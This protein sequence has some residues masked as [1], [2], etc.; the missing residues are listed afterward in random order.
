MAEI[1]YKAN[2]NKYH[3]QCPISELDSMKEFLRSKGFEIKG[4]V[5]RYI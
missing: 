1:I 4:I 5:R 3:T 2:G